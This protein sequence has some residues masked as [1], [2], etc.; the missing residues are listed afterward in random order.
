[1]L[2]KQR[3]TETLIRLGCAGWSAPLLFAYGIKQVFS[4][5]GSSN[6]TTCTC[7]Q[8]SLEP[9]HD[10]TNKMACAPSEDSDQPRHAPSL[11]GVFA[12][13]LKKAWVL[14]YPL[15]AKRRCWSDWADA[16]AD[17]S[18]RWA[19]SHF[20]SFSWGGSF[21]PWIDCGSSSVHRVTSGCIDWPASFLVSQKLGKRNLMC[22][23]GFPTL[24]R[25]LL[26]PWTLCWEN[27]TNTVK[28]IEPGAVA[29]LEACLLDMQAA[30]SLI[31]TSCTFFHGDLVMKTFLRPFSTFCRF[32]KSS[33]QLLAKDCA[34]STGKLPRRL[35]QEQCG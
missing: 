8:S 18:L 21:N 13:H 20:V 3:T 29:Q 11:I 10:K 23:S 34:L 32:K 27:W 22:V 5:C 9:A 7:E 16:Q 28:Y 14:S 2:S 24:S 26:R 15:S 1:M 30:P 35:A 33:C 19:H 17:L 6:S 31:P 12:V 25:F 4:W